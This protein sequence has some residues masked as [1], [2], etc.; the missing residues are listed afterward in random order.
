MLNN[1]CVGRSSIAVLAIFLTLT[2]AVLP[3]SQ[4][5]SSSGASGRIAV[6]N[7]INAVLILAADDGHIV[8][9][10]RSNAFGGGVDISPDGRWLALETFSPTS[11]GLVVRRVSGGRA[12]TVARCSAKWCPGWPTWDARSSELAYQ[13]GSFIYRVL[14]NGL[15][16]TRVLRGETPDWSPQTSEIVFM[17]DFSYYTRA[18]KIYVSAIDGRDVRYVARGAYPT[19]HPSGRRLVF[20]LGPDIYTAPVT[21]GNTQRL[22]RNG[23]APVWSPDGRFIAFTR[24]TS[25]G[26]AVCSGRVFIVPTSGKGRP[27]PIG[28][29]IAD[30]GRISW[31]R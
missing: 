19:F 12:R 20:V 21:G 4:A 27:R 6:F 9:R 14:S 1:E 28:P 10:I 5:R 13:Q 24:E 3:V 31:G 17:R 15:G 29:E 8:T 23:S 25:S 30:I 11:K 22:I 2:L 7:S 26:H 18:G 16:R